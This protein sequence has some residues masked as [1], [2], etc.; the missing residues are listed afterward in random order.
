MFFFF[1]HKI[2]YQISTSQVTTRPHQPK[3]KMFVDIISGR[4][5]KNVHWRILAPA[6]D[7]KK[8]PTVIY[9]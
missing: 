9:N 8:F 5:F 1:K 4:V 7:P 2:V 3:I 6:A